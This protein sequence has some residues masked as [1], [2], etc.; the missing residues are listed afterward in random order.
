MKHAPSFV[1]VL[2][3][4]F[5]HCAYIFAFLNFYHPALRSYNPVV[6]LGSVLETEEKTL[7]SSGSMPLYPPS[8]LSTFFF[9]VL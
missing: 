8:F 2:H 6:F 9:P 3:K 7:L 5:S 4:A 1:V